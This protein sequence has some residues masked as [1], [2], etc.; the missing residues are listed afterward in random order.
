MFAPLVRLYRLGDHYFRE[1]TK[2]IAPYW[3]ECRNDFLVKH[4]KCEACGVDK[5]LAVHHVKPIDNNT[6]LE[7]DWSNLITLCAEDHFK[8]GH[9]ADWSARV[10]IVRD[11]ASELLAVPLIRPMIE[12]HAHRNRVYIY[13]F[14]KK[15]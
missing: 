13:D 4:P 7:C 5:H 14:G 6:T 12:E 9:G 11:L 2:G 3:E 8:L 15:K 1:A 10:P